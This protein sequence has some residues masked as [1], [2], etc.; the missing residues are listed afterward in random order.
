[1]LDLATLAFVEAHQATEHREARRIRRSPAR[2]PQ[3]VV[4]EAELCSVCR[5]PVDRVA[6]QSRLPRL[7][8]EPAAGLDD[9]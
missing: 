3:R 8:D 4:A 7:P 9:D 5:L 1:M 2:R 6:R